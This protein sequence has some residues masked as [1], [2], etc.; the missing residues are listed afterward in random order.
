M[1]ITEKIAST[2]YDIL[3]GDM[4]GSDV[5][6]FMKVRLY[7]GEEYARLM[8]VSDGT[9]VLLYYRKS[10]EGNDIS[11]NFL[12]VQMNENNDT[13]S[14][15]F[16]KDKETLRMMMKMGDKVIPFK[17]VTLRNLKNI[18]GTACNISPDDGIINVRDIIMDP[19]YIIQTTDTIILEKDDESTS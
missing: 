14:V 13:V 8:V 6:S 16:R 5:T 4:T 15:Y 18:L 7:G 12:P 10:P 11:I 19:E 17:S 3:D 9:Q 2:C 1:R